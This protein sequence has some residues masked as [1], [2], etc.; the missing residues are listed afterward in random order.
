MLS[1]D[2]I[3]NVYNN[4]GAGVIILTRGY[5]PGTEW[6][7]NIQ[8]VLGHPYLY[9][10]ALEMGPHD[11]GN[12]YENEFVN[13]ILAHGKSPFFLLPFYLGY[14][15]TEDV[16]HNFLQDLVNKGGNIADDR[17]HIVIARYDQPFVP[18]AGPSDTI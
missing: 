2:E 1:W 11:Y 8:A 18:I 5:W 6:R 12:H 17:V 10:V 3:T 9:G 14:G 4:C 16:M 15:R 13:D 7:T